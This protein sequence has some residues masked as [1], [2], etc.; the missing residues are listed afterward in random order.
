MPDI[1]D[2]FDS[3]FKAVGK[4]FE[5]P[6]ITAAYAEQARR[7]QAAIDKEAAEAQAEQ[8]AKV[9]KAAKAR[10]Y[11]AYVLNGGS[12]E[13]FSFG[14]NDGCKPHCPVFM[15]GQC[16]MQAENEAIFAEDSGHD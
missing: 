5:H 13:C 10:A 11:D 16:E 9:A 7:R 8:E 1:R 12:N 3:I 6:A 4:I 2:E 14:I 15:R